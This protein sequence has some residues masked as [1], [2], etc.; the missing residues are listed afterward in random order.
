ML[1]P[2]T[3]LSGSGTAASSTTPAAPKSFLRPAT[4][5]VG[6]TTDDSAS[7]SACDATS[8][9]SESSPLV[10]SSSTP[11]TVANNPFL[12]MASNSPEEDEDVA[13][14]AANEAKPKASENGEQVSFVATIN[15]SV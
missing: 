11:S 13:S 10:A 8:P 7:D 9:A 12:A 2:S 6:S 1:R 5:Q 14:T 3:L 4:F 15:W